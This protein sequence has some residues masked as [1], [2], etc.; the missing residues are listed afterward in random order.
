MEVGAKNFLLTG[1]AL[2]NRPRN[3]RD[4]QVVSVVHVVGEIIFP[5]GATPHGQ[6]K[7]QAVIKAATRGDAVGLINDDA[8]HWQTQP[9]P[10]RGCL[11]LFVPQEWT[12][13]VT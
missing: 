9:S 13:G 2:R 6:G 11:G 7:R 10:V 4:V 3:A 12:T 8:G 5:P 1:L